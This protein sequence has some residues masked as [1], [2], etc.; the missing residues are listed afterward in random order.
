MHIAHRTTRDAL[1]CVLAKTRDRGNAPRVTVAEE[2]DTR[3][4]KKEDEYANERNQP[5]T[6]SEEAPCQGLSIAL[7]RVGTFLRT[8]CRRLEMPAA[9]AELCPP[10]R[11]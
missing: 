10:L 11:A 1:L 7:A 4:R 8:G 3:R 5:P 2:E 9:A 6:P